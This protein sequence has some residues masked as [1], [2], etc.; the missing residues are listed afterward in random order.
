MDS[1]GELAACIQHYKRA[2]TRDPSLVAFSPL[3]VSS[4]D[5]HLLRPIIR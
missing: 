2:V 4:P 1:I 3:I 5:S